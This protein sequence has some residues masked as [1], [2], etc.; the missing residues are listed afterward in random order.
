MSDEAWGRVWRA[1][2]CVL[3]AL[4]LAGLAALCAH[5]IDQQCFHNVAGVAKATSDSERGPWC[6]A[7]TGGSSWGLIDVGI[8]AVV[9]LAIQLIPVHAMYRWALCGLAAVAILAVPVYMQGL[10]Y[11]VPI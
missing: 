8:A 7:L 11:T 2:E 10:E 5:W 3:G 1:L 9:G 4:S 6:E